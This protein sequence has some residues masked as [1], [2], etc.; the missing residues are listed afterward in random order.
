MN[1]N[2]LNKHVNEFDAKGI[3]SQF[4][5]VGA[6]MQGQRSVV[7]HC[8][9]KENKYALAIDQIQ[10]WNWEARQL[11]EAL[12][13]ILSCSFLKKILFYFDIFDNHQRQLHRIDSVSSFIR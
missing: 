3:S 13:I 6:N 4:H 9:I 7:E 11:K 8:I 1:I 5:T 12:N 2:T 10:T